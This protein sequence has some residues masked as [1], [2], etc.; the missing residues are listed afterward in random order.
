MKIQNSLLDVVVINEIIM[1]TML[2]L[3]LFIALLFAIR[4]LSRSNKTEIH[5]HTNDG[6]QRDI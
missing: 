1:K 3:Y 6:N 2:E 4:M 5:F